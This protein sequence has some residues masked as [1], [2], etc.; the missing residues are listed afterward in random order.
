MSA[1]QLS[2]GIVDEF[3]S[4]RV[5]FLLSPD[6]HVEARAVYAAYTGELRD[7]FAAVVQFAESQSR[8]IVRVK[9]PV[10]AFSFP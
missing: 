2:D 6:I 10:V 3:C 9:P 1:I 8:G 5:R 4:S 7:A